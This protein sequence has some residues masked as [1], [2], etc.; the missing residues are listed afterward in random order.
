MS[1]PREAIKTVREYEKFLRARGFSQ[2]EAKRLAG[3]FR[4]LENDDG[5]G[6]FQGR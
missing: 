1:S 2:R 4:P 5:A 3:A 6:G